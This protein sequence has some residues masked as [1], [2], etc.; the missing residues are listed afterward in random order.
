MTVSHHLLQLKNSYYTFISGFLNFPTPSLSLWHLFFTSVWQDRVYILP[1][2]MHSLIF[3]FFVLVSCSLKSFSTES[4]LKCIKWGCE[5]Q[6]Q[7]F[8]G[9]CVLQLRT[10]QEVSSWP[11]QMLLHSDGVGS[12]M[13]GKAGHSGCHQKGFFWFFDVLPTIGRHRIFI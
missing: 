9:I 2:F 1:L 12:V 5:E 7:R 11:C 4:W 13:F 8:F 6:Y 10:A 3:F